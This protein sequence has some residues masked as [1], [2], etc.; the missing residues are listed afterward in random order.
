MSVKYRI[1]SFLKKRID[2]HGVL[3]FM[4][5]DSY[6]QDIV[7]EDLARITS[8]SPEQLNQSLLDALFNSPSF[9]SIFLYRI[10]KSNNVQADRHFKIFRLKY[11]ESP[12]IEIAGDIEGGLRIPHNS[13]VINVAYSG[14]NLSVGPFVVIGSRHGA[15][16]VIGDN[17]TICANSTVV[18]G[19][20]IGDNSL[21]GAASFVCTD[22]EPNT[23][24]GGNPAGVIKMRNVKRE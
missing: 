1:K 7:K 12:G 5:L 18:G 23:T 2:R 6:W 19:I 10:Q 13:C 9:R 20:Q 21:I 4:S 11:P 22:V 8:F 3:A 15:A 16:P 17:V 14:K 24:V